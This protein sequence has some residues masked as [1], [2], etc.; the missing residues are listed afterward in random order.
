M[1]G[2]NAVI[3]GGVKIWNGKRIARGATVTA[4]VKYGSAA[5]PELSE[6]GIWNL[7]SD[8]RELMAR[9]QEAATS[10]IPEEPES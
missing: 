6:D 10:S 9:L 5:V 3:S 1:I 7:L 8:N 4:D 2:E